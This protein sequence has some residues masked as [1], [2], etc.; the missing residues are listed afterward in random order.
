MNHHPHDDL[1]LTYKIR[2]LLD[3]GS[4]SL[5]RNTCDRLLAARQQA[6]SHQKTPVAGL[7]LAGVGQAVGDVLL[8]QARTLAALLALACGLVGTYYWNSFQQ[9]SENEEIDSALLADDLPINAYLDRGF[10]T[11]LEHSP[12][13]SSQ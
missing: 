13:S 9:A 5:D 12:Q 4:G 2:H 7:S 8:P 11:W 6:L 3:H 1:E 10:R